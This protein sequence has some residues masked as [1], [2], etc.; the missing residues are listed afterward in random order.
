MHGNVWEWCEDDVCEYPNGR[1]ID[2][3]GRCGSQLKIIRGG[4]WYFGADSARSALRYT[5]RPI[6]RG[7]SLGL[8]IVREP[9]GRR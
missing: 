8:R 7:F 5:H 6:D 9:A 4:S 1:V 2:P 3:V